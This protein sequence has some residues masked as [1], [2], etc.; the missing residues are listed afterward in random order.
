MRHTSTHGFSLYNPTATLEEAETRTATAMLICGMS[1][2]DY[3]ALTI[4]ELIEAI[5]SLFPTDTGPI[6]TREFGRRGID[7]RA[8]IGA[9]DWLIKLNN[10]IAVRVR[11]DWRNR[12]MG[13]WVIS[14]GS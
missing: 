11:A 12:H 8:L 5:D 2:D 6:S 10:R 3:D 4:D 1:L 7:E 14:S 9:E 13:R